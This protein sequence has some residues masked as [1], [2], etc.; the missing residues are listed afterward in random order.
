MYKGDSYASGSLSYCESH[1]PI[2]FI[3][4]AIVIYCVQIEP[5]RTYAV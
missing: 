3:F 5:S 1:D 4:N 2:K